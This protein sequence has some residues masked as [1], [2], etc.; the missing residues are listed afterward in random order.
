MLFSTMTN[1]IEQ[2]YDDKKISLTK[3]TKIEIIDYEKG[4]KTLQFLATIAA[5]IC[6]MAGGAMIVWSNPVLLMLSENPANEEN[7]LG[8]PIN[9]EE[10]S[11][12]GTMPATGALI[13]SLFPG[14]FAE[15]W[16]RR[17]TLLASIIPSMI[18]WTLIGTG[19]SIGVLYA[20]RFFAGLVIAISFNITPMY[21][22][23]IAET[24]IRGILGAFFQVSITLGQIFAFIIG[25]CVSYTH[26]WI[27]C[28]ALPMAFFVLFFPMPE[29]PHYLAA[30]GRTE[31]VIK[32]LARLRGK[33]ADAVENEA[34]EIK[35][36]VQ[37]TYFEKA[38]TMDLFK[39]K[40]N[41]KA[42]FIT[43]ALVIFQEI[44]GIGVVISYSG[45]IFA[46]AGN[47]G[48]NTSLKTIILGVVQLIGS[49]VNPLIVDRLGRKILLIIS[50]TGSAL[51]L[52]ALGLFFYLKDAAKS[53]VSGIGW[54]PLTALIIYIATYSVGLGPLPWTIMGEMFS[55]EI[56]SKASGI[57]V[58]T[59][60][61]MI[62]VVNKY[63]INIA[64]AF[65]HYS[66]FWIFSCFC[67]LSIFF[68]IFVV[69]ETKGK[70]LQ[71][72]QNELS[73]KA[74]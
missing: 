54:L 30:K 42:L 64:T 12:I 29:S 50:G 26:Y 62:V 47:F 38:T 61:L 74:H 40:S 3:N 13:G 45:L 7:P 5:N 11:W 71:E 37:K 41:L 28:A 23:E 14:Y 68:T 22:G 2:S 19:R 67:I 57:T 21:C 34:H 56:K 18:S 72:I 60:F 35:A 15:R 44:S 55:P 69:P 39:A 48:I 16:G 25:P 1:V 20:G 49:C 63:F 33:S 66:A 53:D 10:T 36:Y 58:F 8:R 46:S 43:C 65:G 4:S 24:S 27:A 52:G 73:G 59:N 51:S 32:V 6:V 9:A 31:D 70:S 17:T